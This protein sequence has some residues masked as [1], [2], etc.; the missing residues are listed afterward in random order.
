M[1][2]PAFEFESSERF[3]C[4]TQAQIRTWFRPNGPFPARY[5]LAVTTPAPVWVVAGPPGAG[6]TTVARLLLA[7]L[8]PPPAL[9][10]KDTM[11][12]SFVAAILAAAGRPPGEREGAWY[13]EHIKVHEYRGM[14]ASAR[15]IRSAGCAVLLSGPFTQQIHDADRWSSWVADL[16]GPPVHLVW[17]RSDAATLWQRLADRGLGRDAAKVAQFDEFA[18]SMRLGSA[19]AA[20]HLTIDNRLSAAAPLEAQVAAVVAAVAGAG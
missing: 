1:D 17:V 9:L 2:A 14:T 18:A 15:E 12:G 20:P 8:D 13:D 19:P 3:V 11:Y 10:D 16:G 7:A 6:K 5:S 4:V